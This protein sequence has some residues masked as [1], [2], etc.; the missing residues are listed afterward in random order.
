MDAIVGQAVREGQVHV[1]QDRAPPEPDLRLTG[2]E[3]IGGKGDDVVADRGWRRRGRVI[4]YHAIYYLHVVLDIWTWTLSGYLSI[5]LKD[6][7]HIVYVYT[8]RG[9]PQV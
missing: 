5:N 4:A 6:Q 8:E 3:A 2:Q 1:Q 9:R 7:S